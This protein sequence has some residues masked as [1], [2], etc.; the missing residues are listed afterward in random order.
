MAAEGAITAAAK[1]ACG[2]K[3]YLRAAA[4][5]RLLDEVKAVAAHD[6]GKSC[7]L[8]ALCPNGYC[9]F[10]RL[11]REQRCAFRWRTGLVRMRACGATCGRLEVGVAVVNVAVFMKEQLREE[12]AALQIWLARCEKHKKS[13]KSVAIEI[14]L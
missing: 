10:L 7:A 14:K 13:T 3:E 9:V 12:A 6:P 1:Q 5:P 4:L 8:F 2:D 11:H